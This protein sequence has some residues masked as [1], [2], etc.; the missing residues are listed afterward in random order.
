MRIG[1]DVGGTF[2]DMVVYDD[3]NGILTASKIQTTPGAPE[4]AVVQL[5]SA[6]PAEALSETEF[7]L[8]GTTVGLNAL[9]ERKGARVGILTT[10]GFRDV[11]EVRRG[12]RDEIFNLHWR[13]PPTLVPRSLR[14]SVTER[15]RAD[16]E[17]DT[18]LVVED[19]DEAAASLAAAGVE[20]VAV[21]FLNGY[22]NPVHELAAEERLQAAGYAGDVVLAHRLS[23]EFREFER[24]A[25]TV[26]DAY[27][28]P[29]VRRYLRRLE[30][31]IRDAG[32]TGTALMTRSG[33]GAMTFETAASRPFETIMSGPVAAAMGT[34]ALA[35]EL[36]LPEVVMADVGGTS[37]DTC[38]ILDGSP[39]VKYEGAVAGLP[40]QCPWIDVRSIGAGGGSIASVDGAG[41]LSVG[42]A[43]A[44]ADPGPACYGRGGTAA[45][46]TDAACHL[47]MLPG[48]LAGHLSL[49]SDLSEAA[50][51]HLATALS[52]T[53]DEVARGV[54]VILTTSMAN[55]IR[56]VTVERGYDPRDARVVAFGG[57]GPLFAGLL[58]RELGVR[59]TIIPPFPGNFSAVGL[60]RQ[61]LV[62]SKARTTI[63]A[64]DGPGVVAAYAAALELI[65]Q[66]RRSI[67][68]ANGSNAE[69]EIAFDLRYVGQE[70]TLTLDLPNS[71]AAGLGASPA[72]LLSA[73]EA[74]Y[75]RAFG[76]RLSGP[77]EIVAARASLRERLPAARLRPGD[78]G[79]DP[80]VAAFT[81]PVYSFAEQE[82]IS[83]D[84]IDR[85]SVPT[86][87][88][89]PGPLV[90]I[91]GTAT[92]Y[93]D[94][95]FTVE[96][97]ES[98]TLHMLDCDEGRAP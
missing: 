66:L 49:D 83:F 12:D 37:F 31:S 82:P 9:L 17:I 48:E 72:D 8:H 91:E 10:R 45:T 43:S 53:C 11:L 42:P 44:G 65:D 79:V 23:G 46:A 74:D 33:G 92:T 87:S 97:D 34:A 71:T 84:V 75:E 29:R 77:V 26:V 59:E 14:L 67:A 76:H 52:L 70:Y 85:R 21:V 7:F 13:P 3:V 30:V 89:V 58:A 40:L 63:H 39:S 24:T 56:S 62:V 18:P 19:V 22:R 15:M 41:R 20:A 36:E 32:F 93:V 25:T 64:L 86:G 35:R 28:R 60:L 78:G 51:G 16:G 38:L 54:L 55:A 68:T 69:V 2:T 61:D 94:R 47:G 57:A 6:L 73:F 98:G 4:H 90:L 81:A 1:V 88:A 95:G 5:V 80:P 96:L 27:I 50:L